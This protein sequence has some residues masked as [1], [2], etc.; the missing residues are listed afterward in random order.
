MMRWS[1][2]FILLTLAVVLL[3]AVASV[4]AQEK[5]QEGKK[6]PPYAKP[7]PLGQVTIKLI[8]VGAG[9]GVDWGSGVLTYKGKEYTFKIK[10][11]QV[12]TIGITKATAKGEVYN[13]FSLGEFSGQYVAATAGLA[14]FKGKEGLAFTNEKGVHLL[15]KAEQKGVNLT[16]GAE[17][18]AIRMEEAR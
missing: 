5:A 18:F 10:G 14:I 3:F 2:T 6:E 8:G 4:G 1:K 7:Y 12:G 13:L 17:G 9:V 11:L 15:L 16:I